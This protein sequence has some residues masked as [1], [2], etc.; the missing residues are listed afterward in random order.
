M[1]QASLDSPEASPEALQALADQIVHRTRNIE[2]YFPITSIEFWFLHRLGIQP[3]SW[4]G[5]LTAWLIHF[6]M[7]LLPALILSVASGKLADAPLVLW[8]LAAA[9]YA[10]AVCVLPPPYHSVIGDFLSWVWAIADEADLRRIAA[11]Q[12]RWYNHRL[13]VPLS[14]VLTLGIVLPLYFWMLRGSNAAIPAGTL[15]IFGFLVFA[16]SQ[17]IS[18]T[19]GMLPQGYLMSTFRY[20][21]YSLSP[22]DT[23]AVR[24]S[25]RGYNR[26]GVLTVVLVTAV[27]LLLV[28]LLPGGSPV[29]APIV[30]ALLLLL[31][32]CTALAVLVPRFF[33]GCVIQ[34]KKDEELGILQVRLNEL[35][36][37]VGDLSEEEHEEMTQLQE[38]HD[39]IRD[40]AENLLPIGD[41][42]KVVGALAL[43]TLTIVATAFADAYVTEWVKPFLP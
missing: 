33:I 7:I 11:W 6:L 32:L 38:A 9:S 3:A 25:V 5:R 34:A 29:V 19:L 43:S 35:L 1:T 27:L 10:G 15:Y 42:A 4:S 28:L 20:E 31:Y 40:S 16:F 12:R 17:A 39:A 36:L 8:I 24:R 14:G 18:V 26:Y 23:V 21:L 2:D 37:R 22:V 30:L 41:L 13:L